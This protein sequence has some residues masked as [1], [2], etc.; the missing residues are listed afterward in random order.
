[1]ALAS[2]SLIAEGCLFAGNSS[3]TAGGGVHI[4]GGAAI[5]RTSTI[6]GNTAASAGGGIAANTVTALEL[7]RLILALNE[8]ALAGGI[9]VYDDA[10]SPDWSCA[11]IYGNANGD[12]G[13]YA[14]D[15]IG[16]SGCFSLDPLFCAAQDDYHLQADSPCL[17]PHNDCGV[18]IG[19]LGEGC[20]PTSIAERQA[21]HAL[22]LLQNR[23][24]PFNPRTEIR[25]GLPGASMPRIRIYDVAGRWVT[26]LLSGEEKAAG[27]HSVAWDGCNAEGEPMGSGIYLCLLKAGEEVRSGKLTLL[28]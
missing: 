25:F 13:G 4:A 14:E 18:L 7:D 15:V 3:G 11:D 23:P 22:T 6:A 2:G 28:R 19:A 5:L 17:P 12:F 16:Q 24:N 21:P 27:W 10:S 8:A 26:D 20:N 9:F 1:M